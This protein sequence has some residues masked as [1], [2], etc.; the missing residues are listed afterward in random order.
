[1]FWEYGETIGQLAN[2]DAVSRTTIEAMLDDLGRRL[3]AAGRSRGQVYEE[4]RLIAPD[5]GDRDM[6]RE[7]MVAQMSLP[8]E[9]RPALAD[10][11][12]FEL[13][14]GSEDRAL[15]L[16]TPSFGTT[17]KYMRGF[18]DLLIP[19]LKRGRLDE[20]RHIQLWCRPWF[21]PEHRYLWRYGKLVAF[22]ALAGESGRAVGMYE[23]CQRAIHEFTDPLT[24]LHFAL[25][26]GV[27]FDRLARLGRDTVAIRLPQTVPV[28]TDGGAAGVAEL[29]A[30]L[31]REA[32]T[33]ADRFDA[34]NGTGYYRELLAERD[35][36]QRWA[37]ADGE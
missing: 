29:R 17:S 9:E 31:R 25:D 19:L 2:L 26:M 6:A 4:R 7:A 10:E 3:G 36:W 12:D 18:A 27:L 13:F 21:R 20:A 14:A 8:P 15:E 5:F 16:A 30:W 37:T 35:E 34:R 24:R 1:M 22:E 23:K 11:I 32:E 33:L 28:A